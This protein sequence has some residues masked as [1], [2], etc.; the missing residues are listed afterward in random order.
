VVQNYKFG[1]LY[2]KDGQ[3]TDVEMFN[4]RMFA[5]MRERERECVCVCVCVIDVIVVDAET[6]SEAF[7]EFLEFLGDRV[8]LAGWSK[9]RGGLNVKGMFNSKATPDPSDCS[10]DPQRVSE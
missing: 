3:T 6:G 5:V 4:N 10:R 2:A 8:Q 1:V 7:D 9:F